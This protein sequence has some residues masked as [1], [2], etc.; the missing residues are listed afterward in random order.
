M[1]WSGNNKNVPRRT[2]R[3]LRKTQLY[4]ADNELCKLYPHPLQLYNTPPSDNISLQE[5]EEVATE[6]LQCKC[7]YP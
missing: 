4:P 3:T 1:N 5:F 6:R 7:S 2:G